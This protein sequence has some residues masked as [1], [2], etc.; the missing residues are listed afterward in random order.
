M[1]VVWLGIS[2]SLSAIRTFNVSALV[3]EQVLSAS[4][5]VC[6]VLCDLVSQ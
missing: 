2:V 6:S 5:V 1:S 4:A 3:C